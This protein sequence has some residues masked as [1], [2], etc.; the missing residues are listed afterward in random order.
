MTYSPPAG[1]SMTNT[2]MRTP[3]NISPF[4]GMC[5]VCAA[6]CI[7]PCEIGLSAVRGTEAIYP[8]KTN[9]NQFASEKNYPLDF[10]HF[11]I[12]GRVFGAFGTDENADSA[13]WAKANL[14]AA[15]GMKNKVNLTAPIVFPAMAKLNWQDYYAGA[16]L[17]GV[18]VVIGEDVITKD[19]DLVVENGLVQSSPLMEAMLSAFRRY[20]RGYGDI[21]LQANYDDERH[22]VLEHGITRLG[23]KS[24]ELKFGQGAKGI[25]GMNRITDFEEALKFKKRGYMVYPDPTD[26]RVAENHEKGI[27]QVFERLGK[28]PFWDEDFLVRRVAELR[29]LGAE[30]VCFKVGPFDPRDLLRILK[31]ASKAGVDMVTFDGGGGGSGSSPAKMMNEWG[32]PTVYMESLLY[33]MLKKMDEKNYSLPQV[34]IAGG[35]A[36][37][38]QIYKGLALGAPYIGLVGVGRGAMAAAMTG[39]QIGKMIEEGNIPKNL[40][41]FGS[42]RDEIF[43]GVRELKEFY[44]NDVKD[45]STGAIGVYS[46]LRRISAGLRQLMALN[47]KFTLKH[48]ERNDI[49]PLTE[50]AAQVTGLKTYKEIADEEIAKL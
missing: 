23:V 9:I 35:F 29:K 1:S 38:D 39:S 12:N 37:E 43:E 42:T 32:I 46:Y 45:I 40:Q 20:H 4:S 18:A 6:D 17:A 3:E 28:L 8:Y 49:V 13:T 2:R 24:V 34:V 44:G 5:T 11:N 19:G 21:I 15:F 41:R 30:R 27:G 26:P 7:G 14:D 10:S 33:D 36:L 22:Q 16:A 50:L 25:Q 47:R 31:A 48:I